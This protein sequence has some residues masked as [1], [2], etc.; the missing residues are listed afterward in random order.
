MRF[1]EYREGPQSQRLG[2]MQSSDQCPLIVLKEA[3]GKGAGGCF[4]GKDMKLGEAALC[5]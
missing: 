1:L 3:S 2:L 4:H 5:P